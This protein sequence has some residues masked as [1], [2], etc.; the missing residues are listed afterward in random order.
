M[1]NEQNWALRS[2]N[3]FSV[4][5]NFALFPSPLC[6]GLWGSPGFSLYAPTLEHHHQLRAGKMLKDTS[7][8]L[9]WF[10]HA[11]LSCTAMRS[12]RDA[13]VLHITHQPK[14][15]YSLTKP[16]V[17]PHPTSGT[18]APTFPVPPC[19]SNLPHVVFNQGRTETGMFWQETWVPWLPHLAKSLSVCVQ[20]SGLLFPHWFLNNI[21]QPGCTGWLPVNL[22]ADAFL[23][24][25]RAWTNSI[26]RGSDLPHP[27]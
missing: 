13:A 10:S 16:W 12:S 27:S 7:Q 2:V 11:V 17:H 8:S 23:R 22:P 15:Y 14:L 25:P 19:E 20:N 9:F 5:Q 24:Q 21:S 3:W 6:H 26:T 4:I 1:H 18:G